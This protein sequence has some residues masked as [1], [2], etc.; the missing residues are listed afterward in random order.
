MLGAT[1][2]LKGAAFDWIEHFADDYIMNDLDNWEE[3]TIA[4]FGGF[5]EFARRLEKMF[6]D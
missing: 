3:E 4:I 2:L 6:G 1:T 5:A